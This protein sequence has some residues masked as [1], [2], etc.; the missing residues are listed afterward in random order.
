[1]QF[2]E[3]SN[4]VSAEF[5]GMTGEQMDLFRRM[6]PLYRD[7]NSRINVIS[8]KDIDGFYEHH[9]LHSLA[10]ASYWLREGILP[11]SLSPC[12]SS[13]SSTSS[14]S[15]SSAS[16]ASTS[17][18]SSSTS[19]SASSASSSASSAS[20]TS[21]STAPSSRLS[22]LDVGT[23]GGFPGIPLAVL[24]PGISFTL[25][26]S[27]GKKAIVA[28]AVAESLGLNN[29]T[30]VNARAESLPD[31]FDFVVSRAVTTLDN[32]YPWVRDSFKYSIFYL[33]GGDVNEEI[34]QLMGRNRLKKGSV[35]T[36]RV[37]N[38]LQGEYFQEK[39]VIQIEKDYLCGPIVE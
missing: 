30:V 3:F 6:E 26:D 14:A 23:G 2:E 20:S 37:D 39:F 18:T 33:K 34:A 15:T 8:R 24:F 32:F 7:W 28:K 38:W 21:S 29:V 4:I 36:W 22:V 12:A 1:M 5:P 27:V 17:T 9:V 19:S 25:C 13:A 16:S 10:I 11:A 31:R 35:R